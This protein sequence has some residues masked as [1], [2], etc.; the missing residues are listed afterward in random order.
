[1]N[2]SYEQKDIF[3][4]NSL[5]KIRLKTAVHEA[6]HAAA[7]YLGNKQK[8]LQPVFF[9][10]VISE[11]PGSTFKSNHCMARVQGGRLIHSL[12]R[13]MKES[14]RHFSPEQKEGY[15]KA[16]NADIV[17]LMVGPLAEANYVALM[18]NEI[19]N[20]HLV[21]FPA[22]RFYGGASDMETIAEYLD[23]YTDDATE[24]KQQIDSL[25]YE[26]F[27]FINDRANWRAII[28]LS[29]IIMASKNELVSYQE[30]ADVLDRHSRPL[31]KSA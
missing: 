23:F 25:F 20:S 31:A 12:T 15:L 26:A 24:R 14:S 18:D 16:F 27:R 1:M 30:I 3:A 9:Q 28:A 11:I 4:Q 22:L 7:I 6:G 13:S 8:Q 5:S 2:R 19:I 10:I 17:N 29:Q 21:N